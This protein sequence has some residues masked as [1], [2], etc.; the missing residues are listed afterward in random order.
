MSGIKQVTG[1]ILTGGA[2]AIVLWSSAGFTPIIKRVAGI[3]GG[4]VNA[5]TADGGGGNGWGG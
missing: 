4:E 2:L 1:L 5:A 3:I